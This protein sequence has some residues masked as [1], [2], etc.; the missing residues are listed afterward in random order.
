MP[1]ER[2]DRPSTVTIR[3]LPSAVMPIPVRGLRSQKYEPSQV[4]ETFLPSSTRSGFPPIVSRT[5]GR[6]NDHPYPT[7]SPGNRL[8]WNATALRPVLEVATTLPPLR[9]RERRRHTTLSTTKSRERPSRSPFQPPA[10]IA[11]SRAAHELGGGLKSFPP[12][13]VYIVKASRSGSSG[14]TA[15]MSQTS[16]L[17]CLIHVRSRV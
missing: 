15:A 1:T 11:R 5:P 12:A 16:P 10:P 6:L 2:L 17:G 8:A 9:G 3:I 4:P 7:T 13:G 14:L